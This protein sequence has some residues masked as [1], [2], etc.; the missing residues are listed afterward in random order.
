MTH[1]LG[2]PWVETKDD[3][4]PYN[5]GSGKCNSFYI[6]LYMPAHS[7][8]PCHTHMPAHSMSPCH[9][10]MPAYSMSPCHTHMPAHSMSPCHTQHTHVRQVLVAS[11]NRTHL[12]T[13]ASWTPHLTTSMSHNYMRPHTLHAATPLPCT[14]YPT[15]E[16]PVSF[17]QLC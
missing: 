5:C 13:E 12:Q 16:E 9:T 15:L 17:G 7:M 14:I 10:H 3:H 1:L 8:S 4:D 11:V 6:I 2:R